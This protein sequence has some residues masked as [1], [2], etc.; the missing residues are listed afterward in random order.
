MKDLP[1]RAMSIVL[2]PAVAPSHVRH[3]TVALVMYSPHYVPH[4]TLCLALAFVLADGWQTTVNKLP[5][6]VCCSC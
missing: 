3:D 5:P 4:T 6:T 1:L 2:C